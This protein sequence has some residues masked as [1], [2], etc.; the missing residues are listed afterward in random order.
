MPSLYAEI[1]VPSFSFE[2]LNKEQ[3]LRAMAETQ[4]ANVKERFKRAQGVQ[5]GLP[6]GKKAGGRP[7]V[8]SGQLE[9]SMTIR[10]RELRKAIYAEI[11]PDG[12]RTELPARLKARIRRLARR[13]GAARRAFK[14]QDAGDLVKLNPFIA[15]ALLKAELKKELKKVKEKRIRARG[16]MD[17]AAILA[18]APKDKRAKAGDRQ[19]Y[20]F[21]W[22]ADGELEEMR[23]AARRVMRVAFVEAGGARHEGRPE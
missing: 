5:G 7:L 22:Y 11:R 21:W 8:E 15:S 19:I 3:V 12:E 10:Y 23:D 4:L 14:A 16:N 2:V 18:Y 9:Q 6:R 1:F 20:D 13:K 17:V